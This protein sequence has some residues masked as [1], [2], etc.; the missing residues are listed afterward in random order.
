MPTPTRVAFEKF[1]RQ[2]RNYLH[3]T[4]Y[5]KER[6]RRAVENQ[7]DPAALIKI[8]ED[9]IKGI[10]EQNSFYQQQSR[11][12]MDFVGDEVEIAEALNLQGRIER[13]LERQAQYLK[14][15]ESALATTRALIFLSSLS[16]EQ[17]LVEAKT[18]KDSAL[19]ITQTPDLIAQI[20]IAEY[21]FITHQDSA[22]ILS[23]ASILALRQHSPDVTA[24]FTGLTAQAAP[25]DIG[26]IAEQEGLA[27]R[28]LLYNMKVYLDEKITSAKRQQHSPWKLGYFGSG[29]TWSEVE[30]PQGIYELR[31]LLALLDQ[32]STEQTTAQILAA[33]KTTIDS[34]L[35]DIE[36]TSILN[37]FKRFVS[38]LF[39]FHRSQ[40]T[41]NEYQ[42]LDQLITPTALP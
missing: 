20:P 22:I 7:Q 26:T 23:L 42:Y 24:A 19:L 11:D 16:P 2:Y 18:N 17:L 21:E 27:I 14:K 5:F 32:P 3:E 12:V 35:N 29:Y 31:T 36:D 15:I 28:H 9:T 1:T 41:I 40:Q 13:E 37:Q 30:I 39:G 6:R 8:Y 38:Y 25:D 4:G 10:L 33:V 34:K